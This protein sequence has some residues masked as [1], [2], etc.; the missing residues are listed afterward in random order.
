MI[1]KT[2][3]TLPII[4]LMCQC[5]KQTIDHPI[6]GYVYLTFDDGHDSIYTSLILDVL[7]EKDIKATFFCLGLRLEKY[8]D[9]ASRMVKEGHE[10]A[11]H[12]YDHC[13]L[14]NMSNE[15]IMENINRTENLIEEFAGKSYKLVRPPWGAISPEQ[16]EFLKLHGYT[17]ILWDVDSGDHDIETYNSSDLISN[18]LAGIKPN[19][20]SIVLFHDSDY[21]KHESR[22]NTVYALPVLIDILKKKGFIFDLVSE[23]ENIYE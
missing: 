23:C 4:I 8:P 19:T 11:N 1:K 14:P 22:M 21:A 2:I 15:Q 10:I 5:E 16:K 12:T 13:Y 9:I 6:N 20:S 7:N 17:T 3:L 18:V